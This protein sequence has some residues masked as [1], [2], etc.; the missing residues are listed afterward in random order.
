MATL[1]KIA[2]EVAATYVVPANT[3]E[4]ARGASNDVGRVD[5]EGDES[6]EGSGAAVRLAGPSHLNAVSPSEIRENFIHDG[7]L[8]SN[9]RLDETCIGRS[10]R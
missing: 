4:E 2:R 3:G 5:R 6:G 7:S 10:W 8:R 9:A 1:A